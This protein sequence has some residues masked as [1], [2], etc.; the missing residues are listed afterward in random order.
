MTATTIDRIKQFKQLNALY[1]IHSYFVKIKDLIL[2]SIV[3]FL[4]YF[5]SFWIRSLIDK[6]VVAVLR[7]YMDKL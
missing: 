4:I 7:D 5:S 6:D 2:L 1:Y 3:T